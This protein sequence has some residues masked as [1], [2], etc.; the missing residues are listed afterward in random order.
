MKK[1][2]IVSFGEAL[3]DFIPISQDSYKANPGGAP[4]NVALCASKCGAK[5]AFIGK[6]GN[7][8]PGALLKETAKEHGVDCVG[9]VTDGKRP[10][11][12]VFVTVGA[13]GENSYAFCRDG[14]ADVSIDASEV[15]FSLIEK[16]KHFHFGGLSLTADPCKSTALALLQ[17][18]A[19]CGLTTSF[20]PNYR[21]ALWGSA[22]ELKAAC[23][24]LPIKIDYLKVSLGEAF[25][26][27]GRSDID[28]ALDF[29]LTK[30]KTV[31]LTMGADG[32]YYAV[33]GSR[34][35]FDGVAANTVDTTGAG[36]IFFGFFLSCVAGAERISEALIASATLNACRF[37][38][39]STEIYG[40]IPSIP[41]RKCLKT[42]FNY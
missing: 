8:G 12:H 38:A 14:A 37:A 10:T 25:M 26:L 6:V 20:D 31:L 21:Q 11:C 22:E 18:A 29:L 42:F 40:A 30:A 3:I 1:Y 27:S 24:A 36:D 34:V 32:A 23:L 7:D 17:R 13:D 39:K 19:E 16:A 28:S 35:H 5:T 9:F 41:E 2:D 4:Y 15:D 33:E